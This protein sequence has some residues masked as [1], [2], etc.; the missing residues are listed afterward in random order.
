MTKYLVLV[1]FSSRN[2]GGPFNPG[3]PET[4]AHP[5]P[6]PLLSLIY[7]SLLSLM[8]DARTNSLFF[9]YLITPSYL[10]TSHARMGTKLQCEGIL[11][12]GSRP[13][14]CLARVGE[15]RQLV[16]PPL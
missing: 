9:Y 6:S 14:G 4:K 15:D 5:T 3:S 1:V 11:G 16:G 8:H 13:V 7:F 12:I 10:F 2:K